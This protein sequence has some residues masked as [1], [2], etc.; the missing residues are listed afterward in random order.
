[1]LTINKFEDIEAWQMARQL[2]I[3]VFR[4][5]VESNLRNDFSL[6]DQIK[7]ASGSVMDN[8]AEGF[9]RDGNKEFIQFLSFAKGSASEVQSQ[10][11]RALDFKYI[12]EPTFNEL[13]N[14]AKN[15]I[16]KITNLMKYL[17]SSS[18]EGIKYQ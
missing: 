9:G 17:S 12:D 2:C 14:H 13:Y 1:M 16:G 4:I 11:Y 6:K 5:T 8:I 10:L 15:I 7:R 18:F 3:E